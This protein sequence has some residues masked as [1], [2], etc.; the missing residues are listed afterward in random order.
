M[1]RAIFFLLLFEVFLDSPKMCY[2]GTVGEGSKHR[3]IHLQSSPSAASGW[4]EAQLKA[5]FDLM[6]RDGDGTIKAED[7]MHFLQYSL[8]SDHLSDDDVESMISLA[9]RDGDG[10]VDFE[11]FLS[12]VQP[13]MIPQRSCASLSS[14]GN[15]ALEDIFRVLD[16]NGDGVLSE[17]DLSGVMGTLGQALSSEDLLAMLE[18]ATG[19]NRRQVT[20]EDFCL[21]MSTAGAQ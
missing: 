1:L 13:R 14:L 6:D 5:A 18:T 20:F 17:E 9:D 7:L 8:K 2:E 12:L 15:Q 10:A 11:E 19:S 4:H 16:R 3:R 21:L